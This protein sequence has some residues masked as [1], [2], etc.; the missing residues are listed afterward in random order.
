MDGLVQLRSLGRIRTYGKDEAEELFAVLIELP[1]EQSSEQ[2]DWLK[3]YN[4][5]LEAFQAGKLK[6]ARQYLSACHDENPDDLTCSVYLEAIE[7]GDDH[8]DLVLTDK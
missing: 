1:E 4:D 7:R 5:G 6:E 3:R 2:Q 8:G